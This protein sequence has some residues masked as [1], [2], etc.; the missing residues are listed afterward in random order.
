MARND[1]KKEFEA[2]YCSQ[3]DLKTRAKAILDVSK[4]HLT[5]AQRVIWKDKSD[6][7]AD[8]PNQEAPFLDDVG[9]SI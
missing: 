4:C 9:V 8:P 2:S 6:F 3:F 5:E 1:S 7:Q